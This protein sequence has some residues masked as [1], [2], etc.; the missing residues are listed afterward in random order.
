VAFHVDAK[1][2]PETGL[3]RLEFGSAAAFRVRLNMAAK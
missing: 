1:P 3:R 2:R